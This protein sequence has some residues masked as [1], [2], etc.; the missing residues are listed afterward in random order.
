MKPEDGAGLNSDDAK[1]EHHTSP[2]EKQTELL[3][4]IHTLLETRFPPSSKP[5]PWWNIGKWPIGI[6]VLLAS[7]FLLDFPTESRRKADLVVMENSELK[8]VKL[9]EPSSPIPG[10]NLPAEY[11]ELPNLEPNEGVRTLWVVSLYRQGRKYKQS[12]IRVIQETDGPVVDFL[13]PPVV[14]AGPTT[15]VISRI[16]KDDPNF[17]A[18]RIVR[19]HAFKTADEI[20]P[21]Q[22]LL[23]P[24]SLDGKLVIETKPPIG[25]ARFKS[26]LAKAFDLLK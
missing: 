17:I 2:H 24:S 14:V 20:V 1:D 26:N 8:I 12:G 21:L 11:W 23:T 3:T 16:K 4:A 22:Q 19:T 18:K 15:I 7:L 6:A 5:K 13:L 25:F 10:L 9:T